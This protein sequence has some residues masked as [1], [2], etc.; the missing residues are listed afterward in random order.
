VSEK[1]SA[2]MSRRRADERGVADGRSREASD[3]IGR[4]V[5]ER[6]SATIKRAASRRVHEL[7]SERKLT[8]TEEAREESW[9]S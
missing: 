1:A 5:S 4:D 6:V 8:R 2:M 9:R 7:M 3:H